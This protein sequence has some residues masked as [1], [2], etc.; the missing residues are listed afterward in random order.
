MQQMK[1]S[2]AM[3]GPHFPFTKELLNAVASSIGNFIPYDWQILVKALL[4]PGKYLQWTMR[5]HD[6]ARD[7]TNKNAQAGAPQNQITFNMLTDT[8]QLDAIK[9][10]IQCPPLL[11]KQLKTVALEAWDRITPQREP[12]GS[13]IKILQRSNEN[14]ADFLARLRTAISYTVIR[15][16][17]KKQLK[18]L[19][20]YENTNKKCQKAIA[21]IHD[22]D[23]YYL[24]PVTI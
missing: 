4:K 1:K 16:E 17:A 5:F 9:A 12:T 3:Y 8:G 19:L 15:E 20:P 6:I 14:Y 22:L 7:H 24:K 2:V 18:R 21:S 11:H 23:Y 10:Q 13:Y